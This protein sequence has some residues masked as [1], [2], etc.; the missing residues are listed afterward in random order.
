MP[1]VLESIAREHDVE[2]VF[3]PPYHPEVQATEEIWGIAKGRVANRRTSG[4][5]KE[6]VTR[7]FIQAMEEIQREGLWAEVARR[8]RE[9]ELEL[10]DRDEVPLEEVH[11]VDYHHL[12]GLV[13]TFEAQLA[14]E[15]NPPAEPNGLDQ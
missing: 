6:S 10:A 15:G 11:N 3:Q 2:L 5:T 7:L 14:D 13:E 9:R 8:A 12:H 1:F 4:F